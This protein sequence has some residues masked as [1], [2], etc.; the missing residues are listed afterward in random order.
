MNRI[1]LLP[2]C[3]GLF[4]FFSMSSITASQISLGIALLIWLIRLILK[5]DRL[6]FPPFFWALLAYGG[7]SLLSCL[8]SFNPEESFRDSR[9]LL[10]LLIIPMVTTGFHHL[11]VLEHTHLALLASGMISI[12]YSFYIFV[13]HSSPGER[14]TGFMGH[15]MTQAGLLVLFGCAALSFLCFQRGKLRFVWGGAFGLSLVVL[16]LTLTRSAWVG[17]FVGILVLMWLYKPKILILIPFLL[18]LFLIALP[19]Q[20]RQRA[21]SIFDM[22]NATNQQRIEFIRGG[23]KVVRAYP[24]FGTGP[25]MVN[26]EIKR[27]KYGLSEEA[28]PLAVHL[29]NNI[30]Q[31]AAERGLP[32]LLAWLA[33]IALTAWALI[34]RLQS[35]D[36]GMRPLAAAA[37]AAL[38]AFFT[39]GLFEYNFGDSEVTALF[40]Y[41]IAVPFAREQ[42]LRRQE[43]IPESHE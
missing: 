6:G 19:P 12:L 11:R 26:I 15:Y 37:L 33:F 22:K 35:G 20:I 34:R 24:V 3:F 10:L 9:E 39:A 7:L 41:L 5:K 13:L 36:P 31:I 16:M 42:I 28:K 4:L 43:T 23:L 40:F 8:F 27:E 18:A 25:N 17:M 2:I 30:I 14:I 1:R 29:H 38:A 21:V 32:A